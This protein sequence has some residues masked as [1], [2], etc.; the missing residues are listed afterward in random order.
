M[1]IRKIKQ[2]DPEILIGFCTWAIVAGISLY[3]WYKGTT[4]LEPIFAFSYTGLVIAIACFAIYVIGFLLIHTKRNILVG[5]ICSGI[6]L[7]VLMVQFNNGLIL[8]LAIIFVSDLAEHVPLRRAIMLG[9]AIPFSYF[10]LILD[11]GALINACLF[12]AFNLFAIYIIHRLKNEKKAREKASHLVRELKATQQ[13][14]TATAKRD[15]RMKIARDL[16]D[17]MGHHLTALSLQLEVAKQV[18]SQQGQENISRAQNITRMLLSDVREA[19]SE[20]RHEKPLE[21]VD[22]IEQLVSDI[23]AIDIKLTIAEKFTTHDARVAEATFRSVQEG[24]TNILKHSNADSCEINLHRTEDQ[25]QLSIKDNGI[26]NHGIQPGHGLTG[27]KERIE[28][29]DGNFDITINKDGCRLLINLP[30][31]QEYI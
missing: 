18:V 9:V 17:A 25:V 13:L 10:P 11:E 14:L 1:N 7:V 19:V 26:N 27:M 12:S 20:L 5:F 16:H 3:Q 23:E 8:I 2:L 31:S 22:A 4:I 30:D 29:L 21:V 28:K 15:E 24:I 6:S